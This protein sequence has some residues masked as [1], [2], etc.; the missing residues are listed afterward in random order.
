MFI[1]E[2]EQFKKRLE[3]LTNEEIIEL[4]IKSGVYD[5]NLNL[6]ESYKLPKDKNDNA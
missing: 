4:L 5:K 2:I 3:S 6:T 1:N